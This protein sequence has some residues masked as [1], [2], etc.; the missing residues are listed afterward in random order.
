MIKLA[1]FLITLSWLTKM[2]KWL[3]SEFA[4][5]AKYNSL[6]DSIT[7]NQ[8]LIGVCAIKLWNLP[9]MVKNYKIF[10]FF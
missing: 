9:Q 6:V 5:A 8:D 3:I 10:N 7:V 2:M 1:E 4:F